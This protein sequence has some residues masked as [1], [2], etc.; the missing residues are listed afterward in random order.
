MSTIAIPDHRDPLLSRLAFG[1]GR[2]HKHDIGTAYRTVRRAYDLGIRHFDASVYYGHGVGHA[3]L[4]RLIQEVDDPGRL[5]VSTKIGHFV[6]GF[7]GARDLY[8]NYDALWGLVHECYRMLHGRIDL[9]Q[10]HEADLA[11][12]WLDEATPGTRFLPPDASCDFAGAPVMRIMERARETG[13]CRHIGVTGNTSTVLSRVASNVDV[14]TVMCAYNL[15]P[16]FRGV[17]ENILP[18]AH[19]R[20]LA[21][22]SAGVLQ[23]GAFVRPHDLQRWYRNDERIVAR[24]ERFAS[25]QEESGVSAVE[26][27]LRWMLQVPGIDLWVLGASHPDQVEETMEALRKGPLPRD[28]QNALD[29]LSLPGIDP[30]SSFP[31]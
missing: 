28:L 19:D 21:V 12:W 27:V 10:I 13:I 25:I 24:F 20:G 4:G 8:R 11:W 14:D 17:E 16:I 3:I 15:D 18:V 22:L 29:E 5:Y 9:L 1:V 23:G 6:E 31:G 30:F 2:L 26:L 7:P